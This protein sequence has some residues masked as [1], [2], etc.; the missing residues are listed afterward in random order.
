MKRE[1][2][3]F[4]KY[5]IDYLKIKVYEK[6]GFK[7]LTKQDCIKLSSVL[8]DNNLGYLSSSTIYRFFLQP[9]LHN[10]YQSSLDILCKYAG[11]KS[12]NEFAKSFTES[13]HL[14]LKNGIYSTAQRTSSLL[15]YCL[16]DRSYKSIFRFFEQ[17]ADKPI[18]FKEFVT[19]ELYDSLCSNDN[20]EN[21]FKNFAWQ[22]F[23]REYFFEKAHDPKFRIK[24][25]DK[26]YSYYLKKLNPE[27]DVVSFQDY[28]F[29]YSVLFRHYFLNGFKDK[30]KEIGKILYHNDSLAQLQND[31][32]FIF[33]R[34]RLLA[35]KL[36][37]MELEREDINKLYDYAFY[38]LDYCSTLH[39][40]QNTS[41][42]NIL[43]H[44][45]AEAFINSSLP[46]LFHLKLK[47][48]YQKEL[49]LLTV[50][51]QSQDLKFLLPYYESNGLLFN[52][53]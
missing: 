38:I 15:H 50:R 11:Y 2:S 35:Y 47:K 43:F 26:G 12:Y 41:E 40:K 29:G 5:L 21:F 51:I 42:K 30:A 18:Q 1:K 19:L 14:L 7:I 46:E 39:V 13:E 20:P 25:Y 16:E 37:F 6:I 17:I 32:I 52:R 33:P 28:I 45:V 31:R 9:N 24:D 44:T 23:V 36:W 8:A 48:I 4:E 49:S 10:P 3:S 22:P 27:K 34:A 53:P